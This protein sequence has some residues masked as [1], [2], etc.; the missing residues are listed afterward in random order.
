MFYISTIKTVFNCNCKIS[1][2]LLKNVTNI[3]YYSLENWKKKKCR[4]ILSWLIIYKHIPFQSHLWCLNE[5]SHSY[6]FFYI[7]NSLFLADKTPQPQFRQTFWVIL[8][9][10]R[11]LIRNIVKRVISIFKYQLWAFVYIISLGQCFYIENWIITFVWC[12]LYT[13]DYFWL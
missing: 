10:F 6:Q 5:L 3:F 8:D 11:F 7:R 4:I 1:S 13:Q 9:T 2:S 12:F